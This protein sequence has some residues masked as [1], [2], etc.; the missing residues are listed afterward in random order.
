MASREQLW[1]FIFTSRLLKRNKRIW[2]ECYFA[3]VKQGLKIECHNSCIGVIFFG[4][5]SWWLNILSKWSK[6]CCSCCPTARRKRHTSA[7]SCSLPPSTSSQQTW[8]AVSTASKNGSGSWKD[9][10]YLCRFKWHIAYYSLQTI[11]YFRL[12]WEW[13]WFLFCLFSLSLKK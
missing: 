11:T 10:S 8:G 7:R 5:R 13:M 4:D 12:F 1:Y 2:I 9:F 3:S 6:A